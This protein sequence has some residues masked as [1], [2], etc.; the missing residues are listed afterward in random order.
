MTASAEAEGLT[1]LQVSILSAMELED[2]NPCVVSKE[3]V[4]LP[5]LNSVLEGTSV[6]QHVNSETREGWHSGVF[7][8]RAGHAVN[9]V[10]TSF[11]SV[12]TRSLFSWLVCKFPAGITLPRLGLK[13]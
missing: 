9:R 13:C 6:Q 12:T 11:S 10:H 7:L 2:T 5:C 4:P 8:T 1:L 3:S